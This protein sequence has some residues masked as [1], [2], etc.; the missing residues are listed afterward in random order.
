MCGV[1]RFF[2]VLHADGLIRWQ[3]FLCFCILLLFNLTFLIRVRWWPL[4]QSLSTFYNQVLYMQI[5]SGMDSTA[6]SCIGRCWPLDSLSFPP[7]ICR[8]L[9][10]LGWSFGIIYMFLLFPVT[11][12]LKGDFLA[13]CRNKDVLRHGWLDFP[14]RPWKNANTN[15]FQAPH[16]AE[17]AALWPRKRETVMRTLSRGTFGVLQCVSFAPLTTSTSLR[18]SR[19]I[20]KASVRTGGSLALGSTPEML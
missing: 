9:F 7:K 1:F 20:W 4:F 12:L 18:G 5:L 3:L 8:K 11:P 19:S 17:S 6:F 14:R 13:G 10:W 2:L 16:R 15:G